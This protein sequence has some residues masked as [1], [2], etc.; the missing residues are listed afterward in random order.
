[1]VDEE[2]K[3]MEE[4]NVNLNNCQELQKE[5]EKLSGGLKYEDGYIDGWTDDLSLGSGGVAY[6]GASKKSC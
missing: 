6:T 2:M 3:K 1:M 5:I 4:K